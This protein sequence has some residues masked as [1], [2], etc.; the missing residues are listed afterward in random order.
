MAEPFVKWAGGKRKLVPSI[1]EI[2]PKSF[3][4]YHEPM[5]GGGALFFALEPKVAFLNDYNSELMET[6]DVIKNSPKK[7]ISALKK[8][9]NSEED[10]LKIKATKPRTSV[11]V[12]ARFLYLNKLSFNGLYRVNSSGIFNVPYCKDD[13]RNFFDEKAIEEASSVL[14]GKTLTNLDYL[15]AL[16]SVKKG[17]LVFIDPPYDGT[18]TSYTPQKFKKHDQIVLKDALDY[19]TEIKAYAIICNSD[20][21]FIRTLYKSYTKVNIE[22]RYMIG[23]KSSSR[24]KKKTLFVTNFDF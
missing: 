6:Y 9:K 20:N 14:Q 13:T 1:I 24:G 23:S 21:E 19:L 3:K 12:A 15:E 2:L 7:L 11:N 17:D 8:M 4:A 22:D 16:T 10:Y 18:F 5:V